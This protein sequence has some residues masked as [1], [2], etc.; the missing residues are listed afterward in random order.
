MSKAMKYSAGPEI[1]CTYWYIYALYTGVELKDNQHGW[2]LESSFNKPCLK[3]FGFNISATIPTP[4]YQNMN[5][6]I[7]AYIHNHFI[8][9]YSNYM[10][11]MKKVSSLKNSIKKHYKFLC[12]GFVLFEVRNL[13]YLLIL[14][15]SQKYSQLFHL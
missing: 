2:G 8:I 13:K 3:N 10:L 5:K 1:F 14:S 11:E 9:I 7:F 15:P 6:A 12:S 4:W